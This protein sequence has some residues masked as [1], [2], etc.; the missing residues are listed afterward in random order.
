MSSVAFANP[1]AG[2]SDER[3]VLPGAPGSVDGVGENATVEGNQG[4]MRYRVQVEVPQGFAGL[5]PDIDL[6]YSSGSGAGPLGIGWS[7]PS[8]SIERM[9]SKGLQKYDLTDRFVVDGSDELVKVS[10]T[11]TE[12]VYR[13]R[14]EGGFVKWTWRSRGTGEEGYWTA[15]YPDGRVGTFGADA[16]GQAVTTAQVRVPSTSKVWRWQLTQVVDPFAHAMRLTWTKDAS[17][18]PLLDRIDYAY[19]GATARHSVRFTWEGRSDI[20]SNATPGFDLQLKQRLKDVRIFSGTTAPELVRAYVL[21]Y[22]ADAVSGG[23][24]RLASIARFGRGMTA[25]P[26]TFRFAY[27]KTL[28]GVCDA[29]CEKPF[30]KDM[31]VLGGVDFSTGRAAMVDMNGDAL[32]DVVFSDAQGRHSIYM[33][34]LDAEGRTSFDTTPR[35]SS[36]TTGSSPFILG[37]PRVQVL[38][39]NG[40]G[41]VDITQAKVPAVLCNNGSGDWVASNFCVGSSAPGLPAS[42]TPEDDADAAQA[43]PKFVR[44]F[45]Y[46][47]DRRIDWLRTPSGGATTEVLANSTTGFNSVIV[48]N[49]GAVFDESPLQLA[50]MN[51]DGLQDPAQLLVSGQTVQVLYKLNLGFGNWSPNWSTITLT[52]LDASQ[53]NVSELEDVNGDGLTD[54]V[55]VSGNEVRVA[56]NRNGDRFDAVMT[57]TTANLAQGSM[58]P[59]RG[60]N[61]VVTYADMNGNGSDDIVWIQPS[62]QVQYLELFPV[63]PNLI[64]RI[65]NGIGAVQVITYGTSIAEQARDA[66]ANMPW[67]NRVPNAYSTVKRMESFVTLTGSDTSGLKEIMTYKYHSGFY[68]GVEKQ[69]RGY[70]QLELELLSD[71]SRDAQEPG[72]RSEDYDVGKTD[73]ALAGTK[74]RSRV[75]AGM[76]A[77]LALLTDTAYLFQSC[78]V[79]DVGTTTPAISFVCR[80]AVTTTQVERDVAN[81]VTTRVE[82]DYDGYGNVV[83]ER[84][85]GV[86]HFGTTQQPRGCDACTQSGAF[87]KPCGMM[88]TGDERI[89]STEFITPGTATSGRWMLGKPQRITEGAVVGMNVGETVFFY[90]GNDF[91]GLATGLTQGKASRVQHRFGPGPNDVVS[92]RFRTDTHGNIIERIEPA[93][94]IMSSATQRRVAT[95]DAAG[96]NVISSE[97]RMGSGAV[98]SLKRDYVVDVAW[99]QM[100]QSSNWYPVANGQA[101]GPVLQTR[102]RFDDH[103][104]VVR[105][106]EQG[107]T[108]ANPSEEFVYELG[109]PSTRILLQTRSSPTSGLDVIEAR[110]LDGKGRV[111]QKRQKVDA[112]TWQVSGF[113][114][115]DSRGAVVRE[116]QPWTSTSGACETMP[117]ANVP[118]TRFTFD[119]VGRLLSSVEPDSS[120]TRSVYGPL[121]TRLYDENDNDMGSTFFN[122][123][124]IVE[125]DGLN[126]IV[127]FQRS[128]TTSGPQPRT[129]LAYDALGHMS[130][131][132]DPNGNVKS[133]THDALDRVLSV[134]DPNAGI[135]RFE[136][137]ANGNLVKQTDA[138]N[139]VVR[140]TF[141]SA[142]R[143]LSQWDEGDEANT[144]VTLTYDLLPGCTDC[145]NAGGQVAEI[146][147]AV[148]AE[149][150]GY[151]PKG[152]LIYL[153]RAIDGVNFVTR[154]RYDGADRE[155]SASFPGGLEVQRTYDGMGRLKSIPN[156]VNAFTYNE[157]GLLAKVDYSNGTSTAYQFD[158]RLRTSS[159]KSTLKDGSAIVD[160]SYSRDR[161]GNMLAV[162]ENVT[163]TTPVRHGATFTYDAWSR[164]KTAGLARSA[165]DP[166][167]LTFAFD[168]ID[169]V[170]SITSSLGAESKAHVGAITYNATKPNA[171]GKAGSV[172]YTQDERGN[173]ATRAGV[174]YQRDAFNRLVK[175]ERDGQTAALFT[176]GAGVDRIKRVEGA[177]T[178]LYAEPNFEVRD[179]V[180]NLYVRVGDVRIARAQSTATAANVLSDLAPASGSGAEK[181]V[182][183]D[184]IIDISDAWLAQAASAGAV[185]LKGGPAPS[186]VPSLLAASARRLLVD[187]VIWLH[188][189]HLTSVVAASDSAGAL[190]AEQ[191]FYPTGTLRTSTGYVDAYGFTQG[192]QV[193]SSGLLHFEYRELDPLTG[194]WSSI[195]P[196]FQ[197]ST[198]E[199]IDE[200]GESVGGYVYAANN[201]A[202]F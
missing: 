60:T 113:T 81:A 36:Q 39:V 195:D 78:P 41:F 145:T 114:E 102:W 142:N 77:N 161:A 154:R 125:F 117:P 153:E 83:Q 82:Y 59:V 129:E 85:L 200:F 26:V 67:A 164:L 140:Q 152:N 48:Q 103:N 135:T 23:S 16:Q 90:D 29:S 53:A 123:P 198:Q 138:R 110:C 192:E 35:M 42:F 119:P 148:G 131:I 8:F 3:V 132:R 115:Y 126:R 122:T 50:D 107:D 93:G 162:A 170:T 52:G 62:G 58:M 127:A 63:R 180:A 22:E 174:A 166:E 175:V 171:V 61:T 143:L 112:T 14:F 147:Y 121:F 66:A 169:N 168:D 88:C 183:G 185:T 165:G 56:L 149:R 12:A 43:D 51:G 106:L 190:R 202:N 100:A 31:G 150:H 10:E 182:M 146:R 20:I 158:Q 6:V 186:A 21:N 86:V 64:S 109:D 46:D 194:R 68:D 89:T 99:E 69:F 17:G 74:L 7:M 37:D 27:S 54:V 57:L 176:F 80:R 128:L 30:V 193:Q 84:E 32:P 167:V 72:L 133:Q 157:R 45:D 191:S 124:T 196:L 9:T 136:Y 40:D 105:V 73:P 141:D 111:Y 151:D 65:D 15:E 91:E 5:T 137:D 201:F 173:T 38:D 179:G 76:G 96:L 55:A 189:D 172:D 118:F 4:S 49:I 1:A 163:R 108:D 139:K 177:S 181:T 120:T 13:A 92:E 101:A 75:Y 34:R 95:Y 178:T 2:V 71:M 159:L 79:A 28:G 24:S 160:L 197:V 47:N 156:Y 25:Y 199:N 94:T 130:T 87:G 104:R 188:G 18:H 11:G 184:R 97:I 187:D 155:I 116:F 134:T 98:Q 33:A 19:E 70:E 44:F 144:K